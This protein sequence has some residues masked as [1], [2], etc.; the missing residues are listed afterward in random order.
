MT[1]TIHLDGTKLAVLE[2]EATTLGV[3]VEQ[4]AE[5]IIDRHLESREVADREIRFRKAMDDTFRENDEAYRR[6]AK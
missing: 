3:P 2:K 6:L 5:T 1:I 4:W